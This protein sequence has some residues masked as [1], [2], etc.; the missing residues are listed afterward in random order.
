MKRIT[1]SVLLRLQV[2]YC[3]LGIGYNVISYIRMVGGG[4]ALASTNPVTGAVFMLVYGLCLL[5]G[6]RGL[7]RFYR[8]LMALFVLFTGYGGIIKHFIVHAQHPQAY[9]SQLAWALAIGINVFGTL[10][11]LMAVAGWFQTDTKQSKQE[12]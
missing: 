12:R 9:S 3:A 6:Y 2:V 7:Y 1:I 8:V 10:L 5:P 4:K 11:N